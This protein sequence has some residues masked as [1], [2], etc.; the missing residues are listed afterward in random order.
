[1]DTLKKEHKKLVE[2]EKEIIAD[3]IEKAE[4]PNGPELIMNEMKEIIKQQKAQ[5]KWNNS[6]F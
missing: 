1:M 2:N 6:S 3:I 5:G 4:I